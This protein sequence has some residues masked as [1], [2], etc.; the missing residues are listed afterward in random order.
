MKAWVAMSDE[1]Y[2]QAELFLRAA[3]EEDPSGVFLPD[4]GRSL[5]YQGKIE[6]A[7]N[8]F[9]NSLIIHPENV[10][11]LAGYGEALIRTGRR[12]EG[13][14]AFRLCERVAPASKPLMDARER[15]DEFLKG[16]GHDRQP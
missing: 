14:E 4:L 1:K 13:E 9:Q 7:L 6:E 16:S 11:A 10:F 3:L 8:Q 15:V 5:L 2:E 12:D